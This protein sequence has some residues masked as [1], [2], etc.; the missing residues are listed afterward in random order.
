MKNSVGMVV[1]VLLV[2]M[3]AVGCSNP[4]IALDKKTSIRIGVVQIVD[5][6][7][8]NSARQGFMDVLAEQAPGKTV[9]YDLQNAQGDQ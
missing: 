1:V 2:V 6:S 4:G 8:L 7:A 9:V 3:L 5:H